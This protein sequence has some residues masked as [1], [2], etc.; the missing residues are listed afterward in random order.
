[1]N[2][3]EEIAH[4]RAAVEGL[5]LKVGLAPEYKPPNRIHVDR[6]DPDGVP[7]G[8]WDV[9]GRSLRVRAAREASGLWVYLVDRHGDM[10][11]MDLKDTLRLIE[12]ASS[13]ISYAG[14][15]LGARRKTK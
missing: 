12:A 11:P 14:D 10:V 13:G 6:C 9:Q 4:L 3:A 7:Y 1:M 8:E 2:T 5:A 15:D